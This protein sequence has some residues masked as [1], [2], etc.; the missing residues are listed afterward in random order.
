MSASS[1][2]LLSDLKAINQDPPEGVSAAPIEDDDL[3]VW[4]ATIVG[5]A[6]TAW[7]GGIYSLTLTFS[8]EYPTKA[9]KIRFTTEM[10]H[11]NI[12]KDGSICLDIIQ[13]KWSPI[14]TVGSVLTSIQSLLTDPNSSS[15]ANP[16]AAQMIVA[17][18]KM[19]KRRVRKC[20]EKSLETAMM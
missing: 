18:P 3:Y 12:Y 19:Y 7:E 17:N 20:A 6:D 13:D 15:P 8:E 4:N 5:P 1:L 9:P 14:Y 2:R 10:F 16:D 11:P